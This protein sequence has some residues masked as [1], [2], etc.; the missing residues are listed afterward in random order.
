M[1][2]SV[3]VT[4]ASSGIGAA[5][6]ARLASRGFQVFGTSRTPERQSLPG[7][8]FIALDVRDEASVAKGVAQVLACTPRL[9]ALVCNA[10]IGIFGSVEEVPIEAAREQFET[11][12]FGTLRVLRAV[13]PHFRTARSGRVVILGSLSGRAP[14]PFQAHYS[15][16]KAALDALAL[17]LHNELLRLRCQGLAR[18]ARRHPHGVQ[19]AHRVGRD[20]GIR[21]WRESSARGAGDPRVAAARPGAGDRRRGDRARADEP[22]PARALHRRT[23]FAARAARATPA[24]RPLAGRCG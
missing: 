12:V 16:S 15:A 23:R 5:T 7:V 4:G 9:D 22:A 14:I 6:A 21:L 19:C 3:L 10:G 2:G 8:R 17:A 24:S 1:A 11:N 18:R 20:H 13:L